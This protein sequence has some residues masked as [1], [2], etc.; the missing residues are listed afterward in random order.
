MKDKGL[1]IGQ[2][3]HTQENPKDLGKPRVRR[4]SRK[5]NKGNA[6]WEDPILKRKGG[7]NGSVDRTDKKRSKI[8]RKRWGPE[9]TNP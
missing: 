6:G 4:V 9:K 7:S 2:I 8:C 3:D 1:V 5:S